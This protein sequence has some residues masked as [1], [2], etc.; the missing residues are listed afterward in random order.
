[1]YPWRV[2]IVPE[3]MR[4]GVVESMGSH[5]VSPFIRYSSVTM[6]LSLLLKI[7]LAAARQGFWGA[8]AQEYDD[9]EPKHKPGST[10]GHG[11]VE[12]WGHRGKLEVQYDRQHEERDGG[13]NDML[14]NIEFCTMFALIEERYSQ[15]R[16]HVDQDD[17]NSD[18]G[19]NERKG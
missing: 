8:Q 7:D 17:R 5:N 9:D 13:Y 4:L 16:R 15:A 18:N 1:M 12:W 11:Q 10:N 19:A 2:T 14:H 3:G 6:L